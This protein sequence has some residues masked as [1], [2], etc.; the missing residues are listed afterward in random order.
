[1]LPRADRITRRRLR[2]PACLVVVCLLALALAAGCG[3]DEQ[4][5]VT[6]TA[7]A[8]APAAPPPVTP[9]PP[10]TA[11]PTAPVAPPTAVPPAPPAGPQAQVPRPADF[12]NSGEAVLLQR[13]NDEVEPFCTRSSEG[14]AAEGSTASLICDLRAR[15]GLQVFIEGFPSA[16]EMDAVFD[17]LREG[18]EIAPASGDCFRGSPPGEGPYGTPGSAVSGRALCYADSDGDFWLVWTEDATV[19]LLWAF[20]DDPAAVTQFW[21]RNMLILQ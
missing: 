9:P 7:P 12:P 6:V 2:L 10:P 17:S 21:P 14:D 19:T 1:M 16:T 8:P 18:Q 4:G 13:V 15:N 5:V 3:D 11:A 20:S